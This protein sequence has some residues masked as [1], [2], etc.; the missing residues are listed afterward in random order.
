MLLTDLGSRNTTLVNGKPV[1]RCNL[2]PGDEIAVGNVKLLVAEI[3]GREEDEELSRQ[4]GSTVSIRKS[5]G[6]Y[7]TGQR[8]DF[9]ASGQSHTIHDL[10]DLYS[11]SRALWIAGKRDELIMRTRE[12][13]VDRFEPRVIW[14]AGGLEGA[15][16]M[17]TIYRASGSEAPAPPVHACERAIRSGDA[18]LLPLGN[19]EM[20]P[21]PPESIIVVPLVVGPETV[22]AIALQ[23]DRERS[24]Y[25]E[26]DLELLIA[27][28]CIVAP[29][30]HAMTMIESLREEANRLRHMKPDS[31][32]LIGSGPAMERVRSAIRIA[33]Q[34]DLNVLIV[35]ETGSG[36]EIAARMV[37][38]HSSRSKAPFV[39]VNCAA[40][41]RELFESE[42]F[43]YER[44]AFTGAVK[45]KK[46]LIDECHEGTLFLDEVGDLSPE[47]QARLLRAIE[48]HRFRRLGG[49]R[50][51]EV[52]FRIVA[53][54]NRPLGQ[55]I[56]ENAFR[57]DLFYRLNGIEIGMPPLRDRRSDIAELAEHFLDLARLRAK[58]PLKGFAPGALE[59]LESLEWKGN[60]RELRSVIERAVAV[61]NG[62]PIQREHLAHSPF[63]YDHHGFPTLAELEQRHIV[64]ALQQT[65]G[66]MAEA[67]KLLGIG[68][69]TLYEKL[70]KYNLRT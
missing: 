1:G 26:A 63:V 59:S 21:V 11:L 66:R 6:F 14:L 8:A 47:N 16:E 42:L 38:D 40:I 30:F 55:A 52:D 58:R 28:G 13:L 33:A 9:L 24:V 60:V 45:S 69:T 20:H 36:K 48:T 53:A 19:P 2:H 23:S 25:D 62:E 65:Q 37:H 17:N 68:R 31:A 57:S 41:P 32:V 49:Q 44:G 22:G 54:T 39:A 70:A 3:N 18:L 34:S 5:S 43:G 29:W 35:G 10:A 15:V 50:E 61:A 46:G 4:P 67:A 7:I 12:W 27:V 64:N 51:H 56:A